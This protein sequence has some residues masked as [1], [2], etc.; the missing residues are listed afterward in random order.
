L[1]LYRRLG[2]DCVISPHNEYHEDIDWGEV[3]KEIGVPYIVLHRESF[4]AISYV[5]NNITNRLKNLYCFRGSHMVVYNEL[6][7][8][9]YIDIGYVSPERISSLGCPRMDNF[10]KKLC[11]IGIPVNKR[12]KV[13][14]FPFSVSYDGFFSETFRDVHVAIARLAKDHPEIDI[15]IKPKKNFYPSWRK[16]LDRVFK[17][18]GIKLQEI[19]NLHISTDLNVQ[20]LLL[21]TD[22]V[23]GFNTTAILEAAIAGK[24]VIIPYFQEL[25]N[26][27]YDE[28]IKF[29]EA[30]YLFDLAGNAEELESLI[31]YRLEDPKIERKIM[32]GRKALFEKYVSSIK[33]DATEKHITLIKDI[34]NKEHRPTIRST[35][36]LG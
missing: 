7:R 1:R 16:Q 29:R 15:L 17:K 19:S 18:G 23:C 32:E 33:G 35:T 24:P 25:Q 26:P 2:I 10:L 12:K 34:V 20:Q 9:Y 5:E 14:L 3:S 30:L 28:R 8:K 4:L 11:G 6:S 27:K 36:T 22:V 21:E 31:L 13:V